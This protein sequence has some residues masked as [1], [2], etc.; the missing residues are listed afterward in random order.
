[1]R[2]LT[3]SA[4]REA[5]RP[6][7]AGAQ[8]QTGLPSVLAADMLHPRRSKAVAAENGHAVPGRSSR[9]QRRAVA[10]LWS[11]MVLSCRLEGTEKGRKA[12]AYRAPRSA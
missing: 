7:R 10:A 4:S 11:G 2:S 6:P 12:D 9:V 1:M 8:K 3:A 5:V